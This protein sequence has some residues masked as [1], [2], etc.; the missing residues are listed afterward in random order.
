MLD[1]PARRPVCVCGPCAVL[2]ERP[3]AAG[4]YR[5]IPARRRPVAGLPTASLHVPVGLAF[6]VA[7]DDG[8]VTAH[9]PSPA[10]ATRW[11]VDGEDWAAAVA[12]CAELDGMEAEVEALLVN[13]GHVRSSA[14]RPEPSRPE[15]WIVPVTDCYR[16]VAVVREHWE[17]LSGGER[18]WKAVEEFLDQL[19]RIDGKDTGG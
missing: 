6:F 4:R 7:A 17:G 18:V 9:Y 12:A 1:V 13:R 15:A 10:G 19:R 2:F 3:G 5:A 16:L 11:E 8:S 14:S